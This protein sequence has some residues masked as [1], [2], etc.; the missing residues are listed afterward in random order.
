MSLQIDV[1]DHLQTELSSPDPWQLSGNP[2]E[3]QRYALMLNMIAARG[4]FRHGLEIGCAAGFFTRFL[5]RQCREL[6][7][8]DVMPEAIERAAAF[9]GRREGLTWEQASIAA[10]FAAGRTFDLI[11]VA[12][13]LA[14][15]P[16]F[17]T[18]RRVV[19][20][21]TR[22]LAPGGLLVFGS[23]VDTTVARW[24][25]TAG[26]ETIMREWNK[27]MHQLD[28]VACVGSYWGEDCV[29]AA[30]TSA[31]A[32]A[33][34]VPDHELQE[35]SLMPYK[36]VRTLPARSVLV[37]AP[38]PDDETYGCG[39]AILRHVDEGVPVRV[40]ILS[41]GG[42][43]L[44]GDH[45]LQV[46]R[47]RQE[48]SRAAARILGVGEPE[49]WSLADRSLV[50]CE[51]LVARIKEAIADADLIYAPSLEELHPDHRGI[52]RATIEAVRRAG[53]GVRLALYE[54]SAPVHPN[55][56]VDITPVMEKKTAAMRCYQSQLQR[57]RYDEH[58]S[59]LN[60]FRTY[61][62]PAHIGAA[63][64]YLLVS[65]EELAN[66]PLRFHWADNERHLAD[67]AER[68]IRRQLADMRNSTSWK[69]TAPLRAIS[70][71]MRSFLRAG[72][73]LITGPLRLILTL[74]RAAAHRAYRPT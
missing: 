11:V 58:I 56:L 29:I 66:D 50:Y 41:D 68:A 39:G 17:D 9:V 57:Q 71:R 25:L 72:P 24:G 28:R 8:V 26:A 52:A 4:P 34:P 15:L 65:A 18:V 53:A 64:G 33:K 3:H 13:V 27:T 69:V 36:A 67:A 54:I 14:Y 70:R 5:A 19:M 31:D 42:G 32:G 49:F 40:V 47:R 59:A 44:E 48:E 2:F 37:L 12:E 23:A 16:D 22:K 6:H 73:S 63:E 7:V 30:Y 60:R 38:H 55:A 51:A 62:L 10:D 61:T 45:R 35:V 74:L 46:V 43:Q 21:I 1:C 20:A